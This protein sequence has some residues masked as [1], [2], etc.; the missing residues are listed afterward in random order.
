M[1]AAAAL[2]RRLAEW[3]AYQRRLHKLL[4]EYEDIGH[5]VSPQ[6]YQRIKAEARA[7]GRRG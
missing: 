4:L 2:R 6:T 7:G 5:K 3:W 1:S